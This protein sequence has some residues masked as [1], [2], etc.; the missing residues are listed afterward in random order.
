M[1]DQGGPQGPAKT[2][3]V[4]E[5][6]ALAESLAAALRGESGI[7]VTGVTTDAAEARLLFADA[8]ILLVSAAISGDSLQR[9]RDLVDRFPRL[10]IIVLGLP[11]NPDAAIRYAEAGAAGFVLANEPLS[12]VGEKLRAAARGE[13]LLPPDL[14]PDLMSRLAEL[15]PVP[16]DGDIEGE[17]HLTVREQEVLALLADGLSNREIAA[18]LTIE[19]GTVKNHVHKVLHKLRAPTRQALARQ[20]VESPRGG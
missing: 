14:L 1:Q 10:R 19:V 8:D 2:V 12:A 17:G 20:S 11:A 5:V 18:R 4:H 9:V 15:A 6:R 13:A 7:A 3:V 16:G